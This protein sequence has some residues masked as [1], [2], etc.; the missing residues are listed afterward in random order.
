MVQIPAKMKFGFATLA[1]SATM[2]TQTVHCKWEDEMVRER[3][4]KS[5]SYDVAK[6]VKLP[7]L[8]THGCP[9]GLA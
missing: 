9:I 7:T 5:P 4:G 6:K 8:Q 3:T 1:N 2:C